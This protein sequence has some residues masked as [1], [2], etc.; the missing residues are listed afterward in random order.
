MAN[1]LKHGSVGT[2]LTQ[3]EWEGI[4]THVVANQA[5]G[6]IVYA[7]TTSQLLRLGIGSAN[8]VLRVTGG[9][10]DWQAT[11]FITSVGALASGSIATGFGAIDNGAS[12]ITTGG[13]L[14]LDVDGSA[15]NAAG[16]L[17][18][19]AGNDAGLYFS[20]T[21]LVII[22]NGAGASGI[23]LDTEDDTVEIK[24]SGTLQATFSA[25]GLNLASGDGYSI[26]GTSVLNATALGTGMQADQAAMEAETDEN[27]YVPPD[28]VKNSPG[29]A[30]AW[31]SISHP[32]TIDESYNTASY[33]NDGTGDYG[34]TIATD[35]SD[36]EFPAVGIPRG[37]VEGS[38][39]I[40]TGDVGLYD[41]RTFNGGVAANH[42]HSVVAFGDQ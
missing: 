8:D 1:E 38:V 9:K 31:A 18:L 11:S 5:V 19:G 2:E 41:V 16:S 28:L 10:P 35:F 15:E 29:V 3:A 6:D 20:G 13:I 4:G 37:T 24:G 27:T 33:A 25:S 26:A 34:W 36:T 12:N 21:D 30:K 7:D 40:A 32:A 23:I 39:S 22:T 42:H 17:T 14:K